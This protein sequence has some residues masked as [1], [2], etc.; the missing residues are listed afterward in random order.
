M[1]NHYDRTSPVTGESGNPM[2]EPRFLEFA[3]FMRAPVAKN[4]DDL[5]IA[6]IG[7][8]YDGAVTNRPGTRHGPREIRNQSTNVR[9]IHPLTRVDP[10]EGSL[11][12]CGNLVEVRHEIGD[13]KIGLV[14]HSRYHRYFRGCDCPGSGRSH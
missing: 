6:L 13:S 1:S 2:S 5:D 3:T 12:K 10:F 11:Q 7:V 4:L 14:A 9:R 8:P